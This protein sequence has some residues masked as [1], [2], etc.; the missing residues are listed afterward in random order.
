MSPQTRYQL[1]INQQQ[2]DTHKHTRSNTQVVF[3]FHEFL[4]AVKEVFRK[5]HDSSTPLLLGASGA[6]SSA[7]ATTPSADGAGTASS[8]AT[9]DAL[10]IKMLDRS[11]FLWAVSWCVVVDG[12]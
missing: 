7:A 6:A 12:R 11:E 2:P 1:S 8:A 3:V 5:H 4:T 10:A 9:C